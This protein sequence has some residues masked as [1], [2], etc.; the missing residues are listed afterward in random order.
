M[1]NYYAPSITFYGDALTLDEVMAEKWKFAKRW[2]VRSYTVEPS[3][4]SVLCSGDLCTVDATILWSAS[5]PDR[6]ANASGISTWS[7]I[8]KP[9][10]GQLRI[11]GETGK[12][13]KRN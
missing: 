9:I 3:S 7:V 5:S 13:L 10:D 8:L 2:P 11:A 4:V 1:P 12:T 6:G